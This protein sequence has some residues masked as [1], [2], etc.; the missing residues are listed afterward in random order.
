M[1]W[2]G[3]TAIE[4]LSGNASGFAGSASSLTFVAGDDAA[5]RAA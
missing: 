5:N 2:N 3:C 1:F 4:G